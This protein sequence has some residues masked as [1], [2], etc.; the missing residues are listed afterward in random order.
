VRD[1]RYC[2]WFVIKIILSIDLTIFLA[3]L[4]ILS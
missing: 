4:V 3:I 2:Q 1:Y